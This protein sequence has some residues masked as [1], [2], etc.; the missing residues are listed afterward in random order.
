MQVACPLNRNKTGLLVPTHVDA[1]H[2]EFEIEFLVSSIL[3]VEV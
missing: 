3:T 1:R 2:F